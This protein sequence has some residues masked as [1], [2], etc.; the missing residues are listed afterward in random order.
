[1]AA[2]APSAADALPTFPVTFLD[3]DVTLP[4]SAQ[5]EARGLPT[6]GGV[7]AGA[8]L[9]LPRALC[10]LG[11]SAPPAPLK[12][13]PVLSRCSS[14]LLP[15]RLTLLL[16][17]PGSGKSTLLKALTHRLAPPASTGLTGAVLYGGLPAAELAARGLH[18][19][20]LAQYVSQLDEH[21]PFLTVRETLQ[22]AADSPLR[23]IKESI[24][25][26]SQPMC[27]SA[28][29]NVETMGETPARPDRG[30]SCGN[31]ARTSSVASTSL[32]P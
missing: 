19:C 2:T 4:L 21:F 7:L 32:A 24:A 25:A 17:H 5:Q 26:G 13:I 16:G 23:M 15:G 8:A 3:L 18:L 14:T 1:M 22:F 30:V 6:V 12:A 11:S 9:A 20:H 31:S 10:R 28:G 27:S 29:S